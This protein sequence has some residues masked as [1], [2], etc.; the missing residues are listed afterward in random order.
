MLVL[1]PTLPHHLPPLQHAALSSALHIVRFLYHS[2]C[3]PNSSPPISRSDVAGASTLPPG[4]SIQQRESSSS[5]SSS[6][7]QPAAG[8]ASAAVADLELLDLQHGKVRAAKRI[9]SR[10]IL[11]PIDTLPDNVR[12]PGIRTL[13]CRCYV[14]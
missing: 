1:L 13:S 3:Y 5:T 9:C 10:L 6:T 2:E 12:R 7:Q 4:E 14:P 11:A 8:T